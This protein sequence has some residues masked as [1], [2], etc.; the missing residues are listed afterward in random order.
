M[1][2]RE[3]GLTMGTIRYMARDDNPAAYRAL[4]ERM[5]GANDMTFGYADRTEPCY[6]N[7][8]HK[9]PWAR[10]LLLFAVTFPH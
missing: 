8:V 6:T 9:V 7:H 10:I 3:G 2:R 4:A 1:E 5:P